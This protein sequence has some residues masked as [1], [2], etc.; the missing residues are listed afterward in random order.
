MHSEIVPGKPFPHEARPD[1]AKAVRRLSGL[2]GGPRMGMQA[3]PE[4]AVT[5]NECVSHPAFVLL[6]MGWIRLSIA[7][8]S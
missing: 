4:P 1:H 6:C 8:Y 7:L 5:E 3:V 2:P